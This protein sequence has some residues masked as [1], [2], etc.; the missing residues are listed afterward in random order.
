MRVVTRQEERA[1]GARSLKQQ[2]C[3]TARIHIIRK[4]VMR[5]HTPG[6]LGA[7][8]RRAAVVLRAAGQPLIHLAQGQPIPALLAGCAPGRAPALLLQGGPNT[9][10]L[11]CTSG[12]AST[13]PLQAYY[14]LGAPRPQ[15]LS[16]ARTLQ[17]GGV[18]FLLRGV[19]LGREALG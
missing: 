16:G 13:L 9:L 7:G 1:W 11:S 19:P 10:L 12:R 5:K 4:I 6:E 3:M 8:T 17:L 14:L 18:Y 2:A 15:L